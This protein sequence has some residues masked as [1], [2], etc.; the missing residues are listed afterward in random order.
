M[1][2][3]FALAGALIDVNVRWQ[4]AFIVKFSLLFFQLS[5]SYHGAFER[6]EPVRL[7]TFISGS[8]EPCI[9]HLLATGS[10]IKSR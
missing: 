9:L 3:D 4:Q 8:D 2:A 7:E 5:A 10:T 6:L 1:T